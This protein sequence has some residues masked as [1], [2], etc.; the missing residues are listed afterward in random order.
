MYTVYIYGSGQPYVCVY[1]FADHKHARVLEGAAHIC[2]K[3]QGHPGQH[4]PYRHARAQEKGTGGCGCGCVC[5][6]GCV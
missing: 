5:V 3:A 2:H 6:G 4:A 1:V